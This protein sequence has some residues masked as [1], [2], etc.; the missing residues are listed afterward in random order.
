[1]FFNLNVCTKINPLMI[2]KRFFSLY[3]STNIWCLCYM[4]SARQMKCSNDV[5]SGILQIIISVYG[6][7]CILVNKLDSLL[8]TILN[9][10]FINFHQA[11]F[12]RTDN[13]HIRFFY[14]QAGNI[15][16]DQMM[17]TLSPPIRFHIIICEIFTRCLHF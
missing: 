2:L 11:E 5:F 3:V 16:K 7:G 15:T 8:V 6:T 10:F 13:E 4:Y 14:L 1:M 12:T 9:Y 17:R